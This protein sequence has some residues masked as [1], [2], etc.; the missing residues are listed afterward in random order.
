MPTELISDPGIGGQHNDLL[1]IATGTY[2][3]DFFTG[4]LNSTIQTPPAG[5]ILKKRLG[6]RSRP[7]RLPVV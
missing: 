1:F 2:I 3:P 6:V 5:S 4:Q 7:I